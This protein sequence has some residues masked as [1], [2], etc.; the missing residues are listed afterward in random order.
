MGSHSENRV[1][2]EVALKT[3][4]DDLNPISQ[5]QALNTGI[6]FNFHEGVHSRCWCMQWNSSFHG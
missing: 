1:S 6:L 4:Q 2:H 3:F 5:I